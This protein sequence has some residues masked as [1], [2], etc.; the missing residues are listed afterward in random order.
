MNETPNR[1]AILRGTAAGAALA[2]IMGAGATAA[3]RPTAI[4]ALQ[5]E[6][7]HQIAI[8]HTLDLRSLGM[9]EGQEHE[10]LKA[11]FDRQLRS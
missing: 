10:D 5:D 3:S 2:G 1:R 11:A 6:L 9:S 7:R 8:H 4:Q